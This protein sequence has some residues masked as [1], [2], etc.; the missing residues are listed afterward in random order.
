MQGLLLMLLVFAICFT[1][2]SSK[3]CPAIPVQQNFTLTEFMGTW[4]EVEGLSTRFIKGD[5]ITHTF[6]QRSDN[7]IQVNTTEKRDDGK[8]ILYT[9][10]LSPAHVNETARLQI[11][12]AEGVYLDFFP[13]QDEFSFIPFLVL[14]TDYRSYSLVYSC[15]QHSFNPTIYAWIFSRGQ[16]IEESTIKQ[17]K[18]MLKE[19]N[20][21]IDHMETV[22]QVDCP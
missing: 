7:W 19:Y 22:D 5:C 9:G 18:D 2:G 21:R 10:K 8:R 15:T 1:R 13:V 12:F 3:A 20:I 4:Y 14:A 11:L 16:Q 17:L 6:S